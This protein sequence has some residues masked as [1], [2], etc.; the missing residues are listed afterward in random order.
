LLTIPVSPCIQS[1]AGF[2]G[3]GILDFGAN[4]IANHSLTELIVEHEEVIYLKQM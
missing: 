3:P 2:K 1:S 4:S